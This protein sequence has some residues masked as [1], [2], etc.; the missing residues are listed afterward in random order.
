MDL[1]EETGIKAYIGKVN[2]DRNGSP[3]LQEESPRISV[4]ATLR[5]LSD[6]SGKYQNVKPDFNAPLYSFLFRRAYE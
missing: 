5:W 1:I 3:K 6:I 2:M 4:D